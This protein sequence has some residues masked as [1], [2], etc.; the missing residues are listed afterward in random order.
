MKYAV[1]ATGLALLSC[2]PAAAQDFPRGETY[3]GYSFV[4][5]NN[6]GPVPTFNSN[7]GNFQGVYNF[8]SWL[9]LVGDFGG[10]RNGTVNNTTASFM[11]GP[12]YTFHKRKKVSIFVQGLF[13]GAWTTN[14]SF[15]LFNNQLFRYGGAETGFAMLAG[16]GVDIKLKRHVA[17]RPLEVDYFLTQFH[18]PVFIGK[19]NRNNVRASAGVNF[20]IGGEKPTP[21]QP[22]AATKT[23]PDGS[24]VPANAPCPK[25]NL[26]VGLT[27]SS[28]EICAGEMV[29]IT[30]TLSANQGVALQWTVNGQPVSAGPQFDFG[31]SGVAPGTYRI[32]VTA[33][34]AAYSPATSEVTI[35]VKEYRPPTG[36][37][38]ANPPEVY[39]GE[40][41][42]LSASFTGQ[43][44]GQ[45]RPPVYTASEGMVHDS[46]FDS[47]G[48]QFDASVRGEQR[49]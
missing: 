25:Q 4:R 43:C 42:A 17:L 35:T 14:G 22:Q 32:G 39:V 23:C 44:G 13:G 45:I 40:K 36:T 20:L 33:A 1:I 11:A 49:K 8:K 2:L 48:V 46:E 31:T 34:G 5:F 29:R 47:T 16:G 37:V 15:I 9:G 30:P 21:P 12:R 28:T 27:A 41:A 24:T 19:S 3:F 10:Y 6:S 18:D 26:T 7:G 38:Q